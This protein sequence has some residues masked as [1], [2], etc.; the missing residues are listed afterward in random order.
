MDLFADSAGSGFR[1][2]GFG[3]RQLETQN[4]E[5]GTAMAAS[6]NPPIGSNP[7]FSRRS[8]LFWP[9][10]FSPGTK[11]SDAPLVASTLPVGGVISESSEQPV[12]SSEHSQAP[13]IS[14][15]ETKWRPRLGVI[16]ATSDCNAGMAV[17][18]ASAEGVA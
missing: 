12:A 17:S 16:Q 9:A 5:P 10:V 14:H 6:L 7:D 4:A 13:F 15:H 3:F 1:V 2:L 11:Q 18:P 8:L